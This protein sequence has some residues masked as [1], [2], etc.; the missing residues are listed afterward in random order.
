[1]AEN[2]TRLPSPASD[3]SGNGRFI[4][5]RDATPSGELQLVR[6]DLFTGELIAFADDTQVP[7]G[8]AVIS[9][10]GQYV[11]YSLNLTG[12]LIRNNFEDL[13]SGVEYELGDTVR[14]GIVSISS[15]ASAVIAY[16]QDRFSPIS[17]TV[18]YDT[19]SGTNSSV[20]GRAL[21]VSGDGRYVLTYQY[22]AENT[23]SGEPN[24]Y[25]HDITNLAQ[26]L[27]SSNAAGAEGNETPGGGSISADGRFVAFSS[28]STNLIDNDTNEATDIF[29][30]DLDTGSVSLASEG[31]AQANG[32]SLEATISGNGRYVVFVSEASNLVA[33]DGNGL[34]DVF[35][36]DLSTGDIELVSTAFSGGAA[37]GDSWTPGISDDGRYVSF[38]S[39]ASNLAIGDTNDAAD[40]F[41]VDMGI[42][43]DAPRASRDELTAAFQRVTFTDPNSIKA[44]AETVVLNDG[45][46]VANPLYVEAARLNELIT[47]YQRSYVTEEQV[48]NQILNFAS[49]TTAVAVQTYQ[50]FTGQ[51][52]G[53]E[54]LAYLINSPLNQNDLTDPY[55]A[56]FNESNRYINFAVNLGKLGEGKEAFSQEYGALSFEQAIRKAYDKIIGAEN[57]E[58]AGLDEAYAYVE[59]QKGYFFAIGGGDVGAKAAMVGYLMYEGLRASLGHYAEATEAYLHVR[60]LGDQPNE[61][62]VP[63]TYG[64]SDEPDLP[65]TGYADNMGPGDFLV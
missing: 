20:G 30:K 35:R 36:K 3:I 5:Y 55:Y 32:N 42:D 25:R 50:F 17:Y 39:E 21:D 9:A 24:L 41:V 40:M 52:P 58:A 6:Y 61:A 46:V 51:T 62:A 37:N 54:G 47:L 12:S 65:L 60:Y 16:G 34:A 48:Q 45:T 2:I 49:D 8:R 13:H 22:G 27:V 44:Q 33:N 28:S 10:D 64:A 1:M 19:V 18:Y 38:I 53:A 63:A 43:P 14:G 31:G 15:D 29:V 56:N 23:Y 4:V 59:S 26:T 11:A 7:P 57:V